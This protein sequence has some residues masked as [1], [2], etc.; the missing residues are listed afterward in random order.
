MRRLVRRRD[1]FDWDPWHYV[2]EALAKTNGEPEQGSAV[3]DPPPY[4]PHRSDQR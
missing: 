3:Q 1:R 2:L 4:S